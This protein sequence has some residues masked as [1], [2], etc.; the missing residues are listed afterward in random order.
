MCTINHNVPLNKLLVV[1]SKLE[2]CEV[3]EENKIAQGNIGNLRLCHECLIEDGYLKCGTCNKYVSTDLLIE[4]GHTEY[5][6]ALTEYELQE[7]F[8]CEGCASKQYTNVYELKG[9]ALLEALGVQD[10]S[11]TA[12]DIE[13]I[14]AEVG[15]F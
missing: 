7:E 9:D 6:D 13:I 10:G 2:I 8:I 14:R 3:C 5:L 11:L 1:A 4:E 12:E 15:G